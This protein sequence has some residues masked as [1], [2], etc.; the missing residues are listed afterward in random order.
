MALR[1]KPLTD[2]ELPFRVEP[3]ALPGSTPD[4]DEHNSCVRLFISGFCSNVFELF[5]F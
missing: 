2:E 3:A 4:L 1:G 5:S